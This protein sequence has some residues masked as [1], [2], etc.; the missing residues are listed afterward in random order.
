MIVGSRPSRYM[1]KTPIKRNKDLDWKEL[2]SLP[3]VM[4]LVYMTSNIS[5]I[6]KETGG[7]GG[8]GVVSEYI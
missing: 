3:L 8:G 5:S 2:V 6:R 4:L 7:G 1:F